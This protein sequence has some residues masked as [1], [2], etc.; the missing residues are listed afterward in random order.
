M[1]HVILLTVE[2]Y[3]DAISGGGWYARYLCDLLDIRALTLRRR[4]DLMSRNIIQVKVPFSTMRH[5]FFLVVY[6]IYV[7]KAMLFMLK[8][9]PRL[10]IANTIYDTLPPRFLRIP[11][12]YVVH[13]VVMFRIGVISKALAKLSLEK[14]YRIV[15][16]TKAVLMHLNGLC[17]NVKK[18][19][20]IVVSNPMDRQV[21]LGIS[22][23]D[24]MVFRKELANKLST[25]VQTLISYVGSISRSKG[26]DILLKA[27]ERLSYR[28]PGAVL[29]LAGVAVDEELLKELPNSCLYLG[30]LTPPRLWLFYKASDIIVFPSRLE[31]VQPR[32]ILEALVAGKMI[33]S[34]DLPSVREMAGG[35]AIYFERSDEQSLY[36]MLKRAIT[37]LKRGFEP[38]LVKPNRIFGL[39]AFKDAWSTLL[40]NSLKRQRYE[41]EQ[42]RRD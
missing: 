28:E 24:C 33:V 36:D 31:E 21:F 25:A 34:S 6:P 42:E 14:A 30:E 19:R 17:K 22:K 8:E 32:V 38:A 7:V 13:D 27:F 1:K 35:N 9:K 40:G 29:A 15:S 16:P 41:L 23:D 11:F 5:L 3:P 10:V 26:V 39:D 18:S 20:M 4:T 12:I 2:L 37:L